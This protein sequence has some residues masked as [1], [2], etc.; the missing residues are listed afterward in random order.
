MLLS[1][2]FLREDVDAVDNVRRISRVHFHALSYHIV[3]ERN[4]EG[5][6]QWSADLAKA[7]AAGSAVATLNACGMHPSF[8]TQ[9]ALS[10]LFPFKYPAESEL[11]LLYKEECGLRGEGKS[12]KGVCVW[13][14][15]GITFSLAPVLVAK[16]PVNTVG[17]G[18]SISSSGLLHSLL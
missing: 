5:R 14:Q 6:E 9:H 18:D 15:N 10:F 7:A 17:L 16:H 8:R 11:E 3:A 2:I 4:V 12:N 13:K 1:A